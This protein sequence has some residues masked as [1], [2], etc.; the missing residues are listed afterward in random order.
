MSQCLKRA[1][2]AAYIVRVDGHLDRHW[3]PWL[4]GLTLTHEADGT[5][6]LTGDIADQAQLHGLLTK[7]RDL[8]VPLLSLA[9]LDPPNAADVTTIVPEHQADRP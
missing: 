3:S 5:T 1:T 4:G 7:I 8:G 9:V 6:S 2:S